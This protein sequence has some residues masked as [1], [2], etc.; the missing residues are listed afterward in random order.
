MEK[1]ESGSNGQ[2]RGSCAV[3]L[4][5]NIA[6]DVTYVLKSRHG[7]L[8]SCECVEMHVVAAIL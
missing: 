8:G 5:S 7:G 1:N 3:F 4:V 2:N 6:Q